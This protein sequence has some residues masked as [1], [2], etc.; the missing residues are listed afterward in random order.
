MIQ[1]TDIKIIKKKHSYCSRILKLSERTN[2]NCP[3]D[4]LGN[5]LLFEIHY[6]ADFRPHLN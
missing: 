4:L 5:F 3:K 6:F 1:P 2:K